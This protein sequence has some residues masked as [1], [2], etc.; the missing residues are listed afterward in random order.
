M[1]E[2]KLEKC[3]RIGLTECWCLDGA[4]DPHC[5]G[6]EPELYETEIDAIQRL[7]KELRAS[8]TRES[9]LQAEVKTIRTGYS[10]AVKDFREYAQKCSELQAEVVRLREALEVYASET[11]WIECEGGKR[12]RVF[13]INSSGGESS[14]GK[15]THLW[16]GHVGE[17]HPNEVAK[18]ALDR[19]SKP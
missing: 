3:H 7:R 1:T 19:E 6:C 5:E 9:E 16:R 11:M 14:F 12:T 15:L 13:W 4:Y 17:L 18:Q 2:Q 8:T 10:N